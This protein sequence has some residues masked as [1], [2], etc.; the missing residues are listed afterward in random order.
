MAVAGGGGGCPGLG[1]ALA[2]AG[3]RRPGLLLPLGLGAETGRVR[4]AILLPGAAP[5][6]RRPD[7]LLPQGL[8]AESGHVRAAVLLPDR[9]V[10]EGV[11]QLADGG[12]RRAG[13]LQALPGKFKIFW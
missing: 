12:E 2:A 4:P 13:L 3:G 5:G 9:A 10:W 7:L 6:G 11:R 8:G 1:G